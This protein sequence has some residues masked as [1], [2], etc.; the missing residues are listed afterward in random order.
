[1]SL[2]YQPS[3][4]PLHIAAKYL[5][6]GVDLAWVEDECLVREVVSADDRGVQRRE[7]QRR[8]R[9]LS[10]GSYLRLI[11]FVSV[12]HPTFCSREINK[13]KSLRVEG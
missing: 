6:V 13:K 9:L 1:M 3:S 10:K 2:K 11:D 8:Y 7:V 5:G 12:Y 4:E